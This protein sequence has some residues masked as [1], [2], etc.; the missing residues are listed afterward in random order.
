MRAPFLLQELRAVRELCDF[1]RCHDLSELLIDTET[2]LEV[3]EPICMHLQ[4][5]RM[6]LH[7]CEEPI[8]HHLLV[9]VHAHDVL[10]KED[11]RRWLLV[12]AL[13]SCVDQFGLVSDSP[14]L[15]LYL[16]FHLL[17]VLRLGLI[18]DFSGG[19]GAGRIA[20]ILH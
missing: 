8:H 10:L 14:A 1:C 6:L 11:S 16:R 5:H 15:S 13:D 3:V 12:A 18:V 7:L 17:D 2:S 9:A 19:L 4:L 20:D